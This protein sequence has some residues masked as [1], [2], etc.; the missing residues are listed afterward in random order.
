[1]A[2]KLSV[3]RV[4]YSLA[5]VFG[6]VYAVCAVLVAIS[7]S[8]GYADVSSV[9]YLVGSNTTKMM[10]VIASMY[11]DNSQANISSLKKQ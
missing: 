6:I 11:P 1:M 7:P 10:F 9:A 8:S 5:A 3:K 4:G 2:E